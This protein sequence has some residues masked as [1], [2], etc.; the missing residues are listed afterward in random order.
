M[1]CTTLSLFDI[2]CAMPTG[3]ILI[4]S[5]LGANER[6]ITLSVESRDTIKAIKA[7]IKE[8]KDV[9]LDQLILFE[10]GRQ[11]KDECRLSDYL[12][13]DEDIIY[14]VVKADLG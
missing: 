5:T 7:K 6:R 9:P 2:K 13:E 14:L 4:V 11:L 8:K 10:G 3:M 12:I 1:W